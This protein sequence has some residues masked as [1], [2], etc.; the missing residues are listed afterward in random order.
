[1]FKVSMQIIWS[2]MIKEENLQATVTEPFHLLFIGSHKNAF[3][4]HHENW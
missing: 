3:H 1:M 4:F 2:L